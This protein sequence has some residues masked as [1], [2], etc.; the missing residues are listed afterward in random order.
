MKYDVFQAMADP[1]R[2][3]ILN[4]LTV[5]KMSINTL[6]DNFSISRPA[7]SKHIKM[8]H[9]SGFITIVEQG[10]E[11]Y[12]ELNPDG[13]NEVKKWIAYYE[14]FWT[15]KLQNLDKLLNSKFANQK[16]KRK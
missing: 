5:E 1:H 8:L 10:R 15:G 9:Q 4:L 13:F 12:C 11:R 16:I 6:A 7:V 2:R 14:Q 3:E